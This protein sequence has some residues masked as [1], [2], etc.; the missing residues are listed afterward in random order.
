VT[1][2][3]A[4][5]DVEIR[6]AVKRGHAD[7]TTAAAERC[8]TCGRPVG[9]PYRRHDARGKIIEGCID[10]SHTGHIYGESLR[11]HN[12]PEAKKWRAAMTARLREML[13]K[14]RRGKP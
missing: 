12:R 8:N 3:A 14:G 1:K 10:A 6:E 2:T 5:R 4:Q 13:S 9:L 7:T 11:W